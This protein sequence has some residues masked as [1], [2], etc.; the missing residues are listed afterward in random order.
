MTK[1][2][3]NT[4]SVCGCTDARACPRGCDSAFLNLLS[5]EGLCTACVKKIARKNLLVSPDRGI[6]AGDARTFSQGR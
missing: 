1:K 5:G 6:K 3:I 4:C 2:V